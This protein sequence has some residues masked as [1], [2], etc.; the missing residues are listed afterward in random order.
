MNKRTGHLH[1]EKLHINMT[2]KITNLLTGVRY[3]NETN[4]KIKLIFDHQL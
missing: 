1:N 3:K 4:I 2:I